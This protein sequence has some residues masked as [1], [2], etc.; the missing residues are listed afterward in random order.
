MHKDSK[1]VS[2]IRDYERGRY[3]RSGFCNCEKNR[4]KRIG[5]SKP[6]LYNQ[7]GILKASRIP[8]VFLSPMIEL[9]NCKSE[10]LSLQCDRAEVVDIR[11]LD[12]V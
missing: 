10:L 9:L 2:E 5:C 8:L 6:F 1:Q 4:G 12:V 11:V 3:V 7:F